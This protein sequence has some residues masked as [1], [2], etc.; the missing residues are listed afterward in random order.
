MTGQGHGD[1]HCACVGA[2][3]AKRIQHVRKIGY[4]QLLRLVVPPIDGPVHKVSN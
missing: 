2:E 4:G 1:L 3:V